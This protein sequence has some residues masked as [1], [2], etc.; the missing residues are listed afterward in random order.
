MVVHVLCPSGAAD[1]GRPLGDVPRVLRHR[2]LTPFP[3][4]RTRADR[5]AWL[6]GLALDHISQ[7]DAR[8]TAVGVPLVPMD[9]ELVA[10]RDGR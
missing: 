4:G 8:L 10:A 7:R 5:T 2:E 9:P 6:L 1:F 3:S